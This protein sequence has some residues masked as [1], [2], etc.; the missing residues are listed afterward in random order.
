MFGEGS[1]TTST[2][3]SGNGATGTLGGG[4]SWTTDAA[5]NAVACTGG[6][7]I[8]VAFPAVSSGESVTLLVIHKPTTWPGTFTALFDDAARQFSMFFNSI[9][10]ETFNGGAVFLYGG[11]EG[12]ASGSLWQY[13][14]VRDMSGGTS[15]VYINGSS[16]DSGSAGIGTASAATLHFGDNPSTGGSTYDGLYD[17]ICFWNRAISGAEIT[18]LTADPYQMFRPAGGG[19]TVGADA[20]HYYRTHI[21]R[22]AG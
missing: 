19:S 20:M 11:H 1:G 13:L 7:N 5:G 16:T 12:M 4:A 14:Y 17:E 18:S 10:N 22:A 2:D 6:G 15:T 9:G 21:T 3:L 8:Q